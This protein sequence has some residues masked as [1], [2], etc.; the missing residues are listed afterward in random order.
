MDEY[1]PLVEGRRLH[2]AVSSVQQ[3]WVEVDMDTRADELGHALSLGANPAS[4]QGP[5]AGERTMVFVNSSDAC[6]AVCSELQRQ[7]LAAAAFHADVEPRD[8]AARLERL[9]AGEI[10]VLVCTDSAAGPF[11]FVPLQ[12][13]L[14]RFVHDSLNHS[15]HP[16]W[17]TSNPLSS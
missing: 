17:H 3:R 11:Y 12:L 15:S 13:N 4:G 2:Q 10:T 1:K 8:R 9:A 14:S 7:G 6:E 16:S 5:A